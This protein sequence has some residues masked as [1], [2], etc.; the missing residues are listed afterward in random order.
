M[1]W[2]AHCR[3]GITLGQLEAVQAWQG[4]TLKPGDI[5]LI[6]SG[7]W[8]PSLTA[9]WPHCGLIVCESSGHI[10]RYLEKD[11][12]ARK[13]SAVVPHRWAGIKQDKAIL[14]WIWDSKLA[15]VGGD[16]PGKAI[17]FLQKHSVCTG[18]HEKKT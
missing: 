10:A 3:Y 11:D 8:M 1:T 4:I 17:S 13:A 15:A 18:S 12:D 16:S 14:E 7:I 6:R 2:P 9:R 5:V